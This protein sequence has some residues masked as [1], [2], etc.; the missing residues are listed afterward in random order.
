MTSRP[1]L[2][3]TAAV[4]ALSGL[5]LLFAPDEML[6]LLGVA[7][8]SAAESVLAQLLGCAWI[9]LANGNWIARGLAV[10]GIHG[11]AIVAGNLVHS[12][13]ASLVLL[14]HALGGAPVAVWLLLL[15]SAA[16]AGAFGWL[17]RHPP[18]PPSPT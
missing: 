14:R 11:R 5:A 17:M 2:I 16:T 3:G 13:T 6:R 18:A 10:G 15:L 7:A 4:L 8:P 9:G 12:T 1:I